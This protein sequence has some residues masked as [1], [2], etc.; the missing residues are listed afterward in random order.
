MVKRLNLN[1]SRTREKLVATLH[2]RSCGFRAIQNL[3]LSICDIIVRSIPVKTPNHL[4]SSVKYVR[5]DKN[6]C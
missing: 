4:C 2:L 1:D 3:N 6:Q 5:L